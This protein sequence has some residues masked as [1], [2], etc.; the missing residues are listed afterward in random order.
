MNAFVNFSRLPLEIQHEIWSVAIHAEPIGGGRT[1][2]LQT[3]ITHLPCIIL[4]PHESVPMIQRTLLL[5][6]KMSRKVATKEIRE[7]IY[8]LWPCIRDNHPSKLEIAAIS[9]H[10]DTLVIPLLSILTWFKKFHF[11]TTQQ[12]FIAKN[13]QPHLIYLQSASQTRHIKLPYKVWQEITAGNI[14]PGRW[15]WLSTF[16][17]LKTLI[18]LIGVEE[19]QPE[20]LDRAILYEH[21]EAEP[22]TPRAR[23]ASLVQNWIALELRYFFQPR[24]PSYNLPEVKALALAHTSQDRLGNQLDELYFEV[25]LEKFRIFRA[26]LAVAIA[27]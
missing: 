2:I 23:W 10:H 25:V 17:S 16:A 18:I 12:H 5:V 15:D 21:I 6:C 26:V 7:G 22:G 1:F 9:A 13:S 11:H 8:I 24:Y 3:H 14:D 19:R 4:S 27:A 20:G